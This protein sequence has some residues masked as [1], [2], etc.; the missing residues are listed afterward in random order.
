MLLFS[1]VD[2]HVC[3]CVCG[4]VAVQAATVTAA[5]IAQETRLSAWSLLQCNGAVNNSSAQASEASLRWDRTTDL[6]KSIPDD[7]II[8]V[9]RIVSDHY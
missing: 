9:L 1:M 4:C 7:R 3:V 6:C 5:A 8:L 2:V